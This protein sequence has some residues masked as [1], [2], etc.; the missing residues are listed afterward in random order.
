MISPE[1]SSILTIGPFGHGKATFLRFFCQNEDGFKAP[2]QIRGVKRFKEKVYHVFK[3]PGFEAP[4]ELDEAKI[5]ELGLKFLE[6]VKNVFVQAG[7]A[8]TALFLVYNPHAGEVSHSMDQLLQAVKISWNHTILVVTHAS[9][10]LPAKSERDQYQR[11]NAYLES[12]GCPKSLKEMVKRVNNRCLLVECVPTKNEKYCNTMAERCVEMLDRIQKDH[13][14]YRN[15][16]FLSAREEASKRLLKSYKSFANNEQFRKVI[17]QQK[18]GF[19]DLKMQVMQ[20]Q[21]KYR[22]LIPLVKEI[23]KEFQHFLKIVQ[24]AKKGGKIAAVTGVAGGIGLGVLGG[25]LAPFTAGASL[26]LLIAGGVAAGTGIGTGAVVWGI[27]NLIEKFEEEDVIRKAEGPV[28]EYREDLIAFYET[29]D[30]VTAK[31]KESIISLLDGSQIDEDAFVA[32]I[33]LALGVKENDVTTASD[34]IQKIIFFHVF[35]GNNEELKQSLGK[36]AAGF[37]EFNQSTSAA[38]VAARTF[39]LAHKEGMPIDHYLLEAIKL[40]EIELEALENLSNLSNLN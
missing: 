12:D 28:R 19:K 29:Y 4:A 16:L 17:D 2:Y 33:C 30:V 6:E 38:E 5:A 24:Y 40:M 35:R 8:I 25:I 7:E 23:A 39:L 13:G 22:A 14:V 32:A 37:G 3:T 21:K 9:T 36:I 27:T 10:F 20:F 34:V 26:G 18:E 11:W 31:L 15:S 1:D